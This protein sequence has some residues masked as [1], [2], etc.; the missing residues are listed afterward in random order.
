MTFTQN[1]TEPYCVDGCLWSHPNLHLVHL[2]C[3]SCSSNE[4]SSFSFNWQ[5]YFRF[6]MEELCV[7][8]QFLAFSSDKCVLLELN[9]FVKARHLTQ[10]FPLMISLAD[11]S[12]YQDRLYSAQFW[13][14]HSLHLFLYQLHLRFV[15]KMNA[16]LLPSI[17][18]WG[19]RG[20]RLTGRSRHPQQHS[21]D[22]TKASTARWREAGP[23]APPA[24]FGSASGSPPT[25]KH[26]WR[27]FRPGRSQMALQADQKLQQVPKPVRPRTFCD[28]D[29]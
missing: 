26:T 27:S 1:G 20:S 3:W 4:E 18:W 12:N 8:T 21:P 14:Q 11:Y 17:H 10:Q 5:Q 19:C 22:P 7:M 6:S 13:L 29:L 16:A 28:C 25:W 9:W 2:R 24:S 15:S 23:T